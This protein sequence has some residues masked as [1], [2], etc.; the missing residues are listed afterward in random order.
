MVHKT[1]TSVFYS[2]GSVENLRKKARNF[3]LYNQRRMWYPF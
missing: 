1:R 2:E 3:L